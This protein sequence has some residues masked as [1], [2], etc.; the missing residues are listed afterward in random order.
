MPNAADRNA[1][2]L[3]PSPAVA[4]G[5]GMGG[6]GY[7]RILWSSALIGGSSLLA[8]AVGIV[9][10]KAMA[11]L[12]GPA[13]VGLM[14]LYASL[15]EL[16][17]GIA[18]MGVNSSGVRQMAAAA[19][20]GEAGQV[21]RTAA[22]LRRLSLL[23]GV[24]GAAAVFVLAGQ[25]SM[26]TFGS[27]AHAPA[28]ALLAPAVFFACAAR[29]QGALV[30]GMRRIGDLARMGVLGAVLGTALAVLLVYL[31]GGEGIAPA[32]VAIA[33]MEMLAAWW[34]GRRLAF[35]AQAMGAAQAGREAAALLRLGLVFM[36]SALM[37][38]GSAYAVR[39]I[40]MRQAGVEAAGLYQAAWTLGGLYIG[41][42]L[43][44][45]GAD[46]YPR[47]T[48]VA[49][50]HPACNRMVNEQAQV[51]LLLA[52]PGILATLTLAPL[53]IALFYTAEF[54]AAVDILRWLCLGMTLRIVIWPMGFIL[55]AKGA[56]AFFFWTEA[57]WTAAH[58]GLA[59]LGVR[60]FGAAGAG[61]AFFV[62]YLFHGAL[63]YPIVRHLSGFRW[64]SAN[65]RTGPL[66]IFL[67][68]LVFACLS[69]LPAGAGYA[70]GGLA[71]LFGCVYSI[72][73]LAGLV[74]E[75]P[76]LRKVQELLVRFRLSPRLPGE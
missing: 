45:M 72:R 34:Y 60:S 59:W 48:G 35:P 67:I 12:L 54:G 74:A 15:L 8:I 19:G 51:S 68:A 46:F 14:G 64:S 37:V 57:A 3:P 66:F 70:V 42:I 61:M 18:G 39:F 25:L 6:Q 36:A 10:T 26:Q 28:I 56:Q 20:A 40:L 65:R 69:L 17:A 73:V 52:G 5:A 21:A 29:G 55:L 75:E 11:L 38:A 30:Q 24:L 49:H 27:G 13:G 9:R 41:F 1:Q 58:L 4:A 31:L 44:A 63:I 47:L 43:Q 71:T 22:V 16:A 2:V 76:R 7:G 23:L 50:D 32:L 53:V 33:A 62:S